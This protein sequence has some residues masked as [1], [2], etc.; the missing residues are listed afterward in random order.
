M[1]KKK[2]WRKRNLFYLA[3]MYTDDLR[4]GEDYSRLRRCIGIS[5]LDFN[6]T[7]DLEGHRIY[8]LRDSKGDDFSDLLELHIIELRKLFSPDDSLA[9][10]VKLFNVT[11][12]EELNMIKSNDQ[13]ICAGVELMRKMSLSRRIRWEIE[14]REKARRDRVAEMEY[15]MDEAREKGMTQGIEQERTLLNTLNNKLIADNR[16]EDLQRATRDVEFQ[17]E[18]LKQYGLQ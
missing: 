14:A 4:W 15:M 10:W 2:N 5:I 8:R 7:N 9:D 6:L 12:E 13:G 3:K 17:Q 18:L 16:L 11:T 1:A